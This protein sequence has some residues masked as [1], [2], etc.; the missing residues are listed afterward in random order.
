MNIFTAPY[1]RVKTTMHPLTRA[2]RTP[3][4]FGEGLDTPR[5][6]VLVI[7]AIRYEATVLQGDDSTAVVRLVKLAGRGEIYDVSR[8]AD[9]L[10]KCDCPDYEFSK[11][12][13]SSLCK[14][15]R[16]SG[17]NQA[18]DPVDPDRVGDRSGGRD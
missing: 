4:P 8:S 5:P 12:G 9:G 14:H 16:A 10:V 11:A 18:G 1:L 17:G 6:T 7:K 2:G 13:T 3:H 15:G